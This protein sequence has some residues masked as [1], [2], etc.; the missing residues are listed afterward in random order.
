MIRE[1]KSLDLTLLV[2]QWLRVGAIVCRI[3]ILDPP[4]GDPGQI[5]SLIASVSSSGNARLTRLLRGSNKLI[6]GN[7]EEPCMIHNKCSI[8]VAL[9]RTE[10]HV[11][12][13]TLCTLHNIPMS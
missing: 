6:Y 11:P 9:S 8:N 7:N 5:K 1:W 4:L 10:Y 13:V 2:V 3:Q 12:T